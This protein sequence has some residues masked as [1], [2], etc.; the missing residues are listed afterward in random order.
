[1]IPMEF[2]RIYINFIKEIREFKGDM[3]KHF[4]EL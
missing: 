1:M 3:N 2:K 4:I